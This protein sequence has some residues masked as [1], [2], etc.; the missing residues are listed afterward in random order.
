MDAPLTADDYFAPPLV[1]VEE[2]VLLSTGRFVALCAATGGVYAL[3][4][5]YKAWRFFKQWEQNDTWPVARVLLSVFT[6][7]GLLVR[8]KEL[9][10]RAGA[11]AGFS[12][13]NAAS[14]YV[15]LS[16]LSRLPDPYWLVSVGAFGFLVSGFEA[17]NC[18]LPRL[19]GVPLRE[20]TGFSGRQWVLLVGGVLFWALL[21]IGLAL[22]ENGQV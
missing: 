21:L 1:Y 2:Q 14:G 16:L 11:P 20:P 13:G 8:I 22:P 12:P 15:V 17:L 18:T 10:R 19:H 5:Q 4:W 3:W 6:I 9:A 7:Y